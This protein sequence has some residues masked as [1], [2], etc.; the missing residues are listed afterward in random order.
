MSK[1]PEKTISQT[2]ESNKD[3]SWICDHLF[4]PFETPEPLT[5]ISAMSNVEPSMYTLFVC[6]FILH[7]K[8][9]PSK[10]CLPFSLI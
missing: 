8:A 5:S 10:I 1:K 7:R 9:E 3:K 2:M 4:G 6:D